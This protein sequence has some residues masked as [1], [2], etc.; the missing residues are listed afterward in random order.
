MSERSTRVLSFP[1][2]A[3]ARYELRCWGEFSLID[4]LRGSDCAPRG[5]K[6]RALIAFLASHNGAAVGRERLCGL[7]WSER[8]DQQARASLRQ[9]LLELKPLAAG[10]ARL[11]VVERDV[12][13]LNMIGL[14]SDLVRTETHAADDDLEGLAQA[15]SERGERLYGGLDGLD[16]AFD[17]WLAAERRL[18]QDRL[19]SL[20]VAAAERGLKRGDFQAASRLATTLQALDPANEAVAQI[21]MRA[22]HGCG[23][24]SAV[25]RR[26]RRLSDALR[27]DL[28]VAPSPETEAV[29]VEL[30]G[31]ERPPKATSP[32]EA[33][34]VVKPAA[35]PQAAATSVE[36]EPPPH[37]EA[38]SAY[39]RAG[40]LPT[41]R[42][43]VLK[44]LLTRPRIAA[45]AGL[46]VL[47]AAAAGAGWFYWRELTGAPAASRVAFA[48]FTP[49]EP[50]AASKDFAGRLND[51]VTGV[52]KENVPG[53]SIVDASAAGSPK[54]LLQVGG[55]VAR[56]DGKWR[57][58]STIV[59]TRSGVT[60]WSRE[61]NRPPT[62]EAKLEFEVAGATGGVIEDAV[63]A[64][65]EKAARR[66]P[67]ALALLLQSSDAIKSPGL[68][69]RGEPRRLLEEAVAREPDF[70]TAR[71]TLAL[72]LLGESLMG[73]PN[74]RSALKARA[75]REAERAIRS[76]ATAAGSAYGALYL[77]ARGDAPGDL[78]AAENV[79][80]EGLA[81][82]P[83]FPYLAMF[84]CQFLMAVGRPFEGIPFC[85]RALALRPLASPLGYRYAE[86]LY[87]ARQPNLAAQAIDE[88]IRLHPEGSQN[89]RVQF[90]IAAFSGRPEDALALLHS[91][92]PLDL[93]GCGFPN[94][95]VEG[96]K[97]MELFLQAR[98][99]GSAADA[100]R[101]MAA[102]DAATR[103]RLLHPRYF[104]FAAAAL[105]RLDAAFDM[106]DKVA[107]L[108]PY[109][110]AWDPGMLLEGPSRP[111]QRDPR[112]WPLAAKAGLVRYW[113]TRGVWPDFCA[114][115]T[116]PYECRK[117]AARVAGVAPAKAPL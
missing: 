13:R 25:R 77:M 32:A 56:E 57:V 91:A 110:L 86:I 12:L 62:E 75:R 20:G 29:L 69:N 96:V 39:D 21:G 108:A 78:A 2:P 87:A 72:A 36:P 116:L 17:E 14:S 8:G 24:P 41:A 46:V 83:R 84:R 31:G 18:Q 19:L 95:S 99:S 74:D 105:G 45:V 113:R 102:L 7:L 51:Q 22:D 54:P 59:D 88:A 35:A 34:A 42:P 10:P 100:D 71:A 63:D 82:T 58:R 112:F 27:Q 66:D 37:A 94:F 60:L 4:R 70:V 52:L 81:K 79:L 107:A 76:D 38:P 115:P 68:M 47:L 50:D 30:T 15:L 28:G 55:S 80:I 40:D 98:K 6:A 93:C 97:A 85:Q 67:K 114:D 3:T 104:I 23:D 33:A 61:F 106:L 109:L 73:P 90:E 64:L 44:P 11:V 103:D 53:V 26:Y 111:L 101:A 65:Q 49:I 89:Q 48:R 117:E 1:E 5:R 92:P 9:T 16:P 43:A